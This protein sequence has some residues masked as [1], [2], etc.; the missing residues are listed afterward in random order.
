MSPDAPE[1]LLEER[2]YE[3]LTRRVLM[4]PPR[5]PLEEAAIQ[6]EY[7]R[8]VPEAKLMFDWA[9][10]L[11]RQ[12][13]DVWADEGIALGE[14]DRHMTEI[15]AYYRCER[16]PSIPPDRSAGSRNAQSASPRYLAR[17]DPRQKRSLPPW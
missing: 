1:S 17:P 7:A 4:R 3:R 10:V 16:I 14:K 11:H 8:L 9:H 2:I 13:Y 12:A 15:L 6:V 5:L